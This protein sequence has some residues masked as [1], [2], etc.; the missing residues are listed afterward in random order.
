MSSLRVVSSS[1][2]ALCFHACS[3][4]E[5]ALY[6]HGGVTDRLSSEPTSA[7]WKFN[8]SSVTW[9]QIDS[10]GSPRL[11]HHAA[12]TQHDRYL[13]LIG[14]WTG[15]S[16]TPEVHIFDC[17]EQKWYD[18]RTEG[19]PAGAGLSSHTATLLRDGSIFVTGREGGLRTQRRSGST[20]RLSGDAAK[21]C[22]FRYSDNSMGMASRSGHT[23]VPLTRDQLAIIG[24]RSDNLLECI[25]RVP[26]VISTHP[27]LSTKLSALSEEIKPS[28]KPPGG[29]KNH[30]SVS[31][32]DMVVVHGGETFDGRAKAS[33]SDIWVLDTRGGCLRWMRVCSGNAV[34][35]AA[36]GVWVAEDA[37]FIHGGFDERGKTSSEVIKLDL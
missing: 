15:K 35:R 13:I 10:P 20:F 32:G 33:V 1:G 18:C 24:G 22:V 19:F 25:G 5:D 3:V 31:T 6:V 11:S 8:F 27:E 16:R 36:H 9:S 34:A 12:V 23:A 28:A 21:S 30:V 26:V 37:I 14:G 17:L 4:V 29:R 2:P 7:L